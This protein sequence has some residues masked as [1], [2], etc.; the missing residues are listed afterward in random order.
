MS[1][2]ISI[3][4]KDILQ[5]GICVLMLER[6][7]CVQCIHSY[8]CYSDDSSYHPTSTQL[9]RLL[10]N[11]PSPSVIDLDNKPLEHLTTIQLHE[12]KATLEFTSLSSSISVLS[13]RHILC[14][15]PLLRR[16]LPHRLANVLAAANDTGHFKL[17]SLVN[18]S[19]TYANAL[20]AASSTLTDDPVA[21]NFFADELGIKGWREAKLMLE[22]EAALVRRGWLQHWEVVLCAC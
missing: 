4:Y 17:S 9:V 14:M 3:S 13:T 10:S 8:L 19:V 1:S 12:G 11:S 16:R 21:R 6:N 7:V 22:F 2:A 20:A 15:V 5:V 18:S